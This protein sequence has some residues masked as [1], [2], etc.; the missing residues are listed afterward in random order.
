LYCS[1]LELFFLLFFR[2]ENNDQIHKGSIIKNTKEYK[3][4]LPICPYLSL[5]LYKAKYP[6]SKITSKSVFHISV[7][8]LPIR[9]IHNTVER[10][11]QK[12]VN[13]PGLKNQRQTVIGKQTKPKMKGIMGAVSSIPSATIQ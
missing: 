5:K 11:I 10:K 12:D 9:I 2:E 3:N 8:P 4:F 6:L 1:N 13:T 7:V